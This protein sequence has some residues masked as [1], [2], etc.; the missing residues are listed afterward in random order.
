MD[1]FEIVCC[2]KLL[3]ILLKCMFYIGGSRMATIK[4]TGYLID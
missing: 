2:K 4:I 1:H 3:H